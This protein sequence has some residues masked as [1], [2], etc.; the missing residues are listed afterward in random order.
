MNEQTDYTD[1]SHGLPFDPT[2]NLRK[3]LQLR[4][5]ER[6]ESGE[7]FFEGAVAPN[8]GPRV[9]GGQ[10]IGQ[11]IMAANAT[12]PDGRYIHSMHG[13][14]LRG[15]DAERPIEFGVENLRDGRSFSA[16]RVHAFQDGRTLL[17]MIA[18]FQDYDEG[19][20]HYD[21]VP[22]DAPDPESLPST[23]D[24]L[25][26]IDHPAAKFWAEQRPFDVRHVQK[27]LYLPSEK[28]EI[29][30]DNAVWMK[31][32][33]RIEGPQAV[34]R[35]ALAYASDYTLLEPVLRRHGLNWAI[36]GMSIASLDHA[37]WFHRDVRVDDWL[38]YVQH[39]PNAT[40]ARG[41]GTGRIYNRDGLLVASVGQEGMI[42]VPEKFMHR[43]D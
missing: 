43:A 28:Q 10:V 31:T 20:D 26:S 16:R 6:E 42:R 7:D 37:M 30:P 9:F 22:I 35:A 19:V 24:L 4:P 14:F 32:F 27:H 13:Y 18:S 2:E 5:L 39:S 41:L 8:P 40:G 11:A 3:V 38:L 36:P 1:T 12:M 23:A 25:G 21:P 33:T 17:S 34:H 29:S 15:G